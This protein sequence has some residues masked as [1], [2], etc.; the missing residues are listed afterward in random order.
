MVLESWSSALSLDLAFTAC[1]GVLFIL[2]VAFLWKSRPKYI[3]GLPRLRS[4]SLVLGDTLASIRNLHRLHDFLLEQCEQLGDTYCLSVPFST[5]AIVTRSPKNIEYILKTNFDNF[6]KGDRFREML[7]DLLGRGIFAVDGQEWREKRKTASHMFS[8]KVL[9]EDMT[10]M[11]HRHGATLLSVLAECARAGQV[12]DLQDMFFR[13]TLDSIAEIAFGQNLDALHC[14]KH[15]FAVAFDRAQHLC[16]R[17]SISPPFIWKTLKC[18][19]CGEEREITRHCRFLRAFC[20]EMARKRLAEG[21]SRLRRFPDLLSRF[22]SEARDRGEELSDDYLCDTVLNFMVAGRDTTACLLSW[23][24]FELCKHPETEP[25]LLEELARMRAENCASHNPRD[26]LAFW[27]P[28]YE[29]C[30]RMTCMEAFLRE[31]LRLHPSVPIDPKFTVAPCVLPD[32]NVEIP[33]GTMVNYFIAGMAHSKAIWGP[34]ASQFRPERWLDGSC[35]PSQFDYPVFNAGPRLCLGQHVA[36]L[37]AK[38]AFAALLNRFQLSSRL[39][40]RDR[41]PLYQVSIVMPLKHGMPVMLSE[42]GG[43]ASV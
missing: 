26:P 10:A 24:C 38:M 19:Q 43:A 29:Q 35:S 27:A 20:T 8:E 3:K 2:F 32:G 39:V 23:S 6:Q 41:E 5:S 9:R 34:D 21:E 1:A 42:R 15:P 16:A 18:F 22:I 37:E 12:V 7:G 4:S 17:R 14:P 13:F 28:T 30:H 40:E 36:L 31:A 11:F 25:A 33:A